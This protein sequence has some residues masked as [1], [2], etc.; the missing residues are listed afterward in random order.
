MIAKFKSSWQLF[1]A[2]IAVTLRHRKLLLFPVLTTCLTTLIALFFLSAMALPVVLYHTGY[3]LD[4]REH[5]AALSNH[6]APQRAHHTQP[7]DPAS[8][9]SEA[10][11]GLLTDLSAAVGQPGQTGAAH[12]FPW[13]SL[14]LLVLY[15]VSMFLATFFNV[16][17][18]SE[19]IA[20]L[21]G[22][23]VS[24]RRGLATA[25]SRLPSIVTWSLLAG[26]VGWLIRTIE[27]RLP[28]AGR[29]VTGLIGMAWSVAAVFAIP[30]IIQEQSM[31]N[32]IKILQQS[33]ATLKRTW[34]ESL[35]GYLGFSAGNVVIFMV[36]LL[37]LLLAG[38]VAL[39]FKSVALIVIAGIVWV[40]ALLLMAYLSGVAAHVFRCALYK[41]ATEGVVPEPYSP[42]L[43]DMAWK[44]K[45]GSGGD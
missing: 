20:A 11:S 38:V 12:G 17:F 8:N 23:G 13:A 32:P 37:P 16:A 36:S 4:Q 27:Q 18:Y 25:R 21:D 39:L 24:F 41:Y 19:I 10:L 26:I 7:R 14:A 2:S 1:K 3:R 22:R 15:F 44:V 42:E 33:A 6:Y 43:M 35:V 9:A 31:R 30:V 45:S 29:I 5:W 40:L 28:L 34:G